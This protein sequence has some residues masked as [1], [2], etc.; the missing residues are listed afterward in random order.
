MSLA[1]KRRRGP[2]WVIRASVFPRRWGRTKSASLLK[3]QGRA[4][5]NM[6]S[7]IY[8]SQ[9]DKKLEDG[10]PCVWG[11]LATRTFKLRRLP[12]LDWRT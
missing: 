9:G 12:F 10:N 2:G 3:R 8:I 4:L 11:Y 5:P 7:D 1:S 6:I